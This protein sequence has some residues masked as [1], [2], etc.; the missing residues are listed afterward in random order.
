MTTKGPKIRST[1]RN[2]EFSIKNICVFP[3]VQRVFRTQ[4]QRNNIKYKKIGNLESGKYYKYMDLETALICLENKTFRF[5]EPSTWQ[6][7]YESRFYNANYSNVLNGKEE[8]QECPILYSNC[9]TNKK[10]NEAAW[11]IYTYGKNGLG[12]R[13]VEFTL[14]KTRLREQLINNLKD[15]TIYEGN[16]L[17][18]WEGDIDTLH[19]KRI[20]VNK[21][22]ENNPWYDFFFTDFDLEK[23]LNL[24]LL[25]RDAFEHE[26]ESRI[27]IVPDVSTVEKGKKHIVNGKKICGTRL[28]INDSDVVFDWGKVIE[29]VRFDDSCTPVEINLLRKAVKKAIDFQGNDEDWEND[30]RYP[31]CYH[32][33]GV[34]KQIKIQ[35]K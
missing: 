31:H 18:V 19:Q 14:N 7:N 32:I 26:K 35:K 13:C 10:N 29:E 11:K 21:K 3:S 28:I 33:Y 30:K 9:V 5:V 24:M 22:Y 25:K 20:Q 2:E 27:M 6:D 1:E 16:V 12:A 15:C 34:R 17:Y 23:Y 4:I 8:T